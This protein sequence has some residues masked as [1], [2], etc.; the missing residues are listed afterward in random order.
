MTLTMDYTIGVTAKDP[1]TYWFIITIGS[2]QVQLKVGDGG[3]SY[4]KTIKGGASKSKGSIA[5][6]FLVT[7]GT[8]L[9]SG[10]ITATDVT[11]GPPP[12]LRGHVEFGD[13]QKRLP[14]ADVVASDSFPWSA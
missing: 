13:A 2:T 4:T 5:V 14:A 11:K 1:D 3:H 9:A 10:L 6:T 12:V 7:K 8:H